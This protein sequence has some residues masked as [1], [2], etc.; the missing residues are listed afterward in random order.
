LRPNKHRQLR[1]VS[2]GMRMQMQRQ[3]KTENTYY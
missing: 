2:W 3:K 1:L